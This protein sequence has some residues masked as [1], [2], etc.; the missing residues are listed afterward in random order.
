MLVVVDAVF[1]LI[2]ALDMLLGYLLRSVMVFGVVA[3]TVVGYYA[4]DDDAGVVV[5]G[6]VVCVG[7]DFGDRVVVGSVVGV[8]GL[9]L[10][11]CCCCCVRVMMIVIVCM[12][13]LV[14]VVLV[15]LLTSVLLWVCW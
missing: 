5:C 9:C 7:V 4:D 11:C 6:V 1:M 13:M 8:V 12:L 15:M 10:R 14:L 2:V 3:V